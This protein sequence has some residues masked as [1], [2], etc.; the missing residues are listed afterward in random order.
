MSQD[1]RSEGNQPS[2]A[3]AISRVARHS[4]VARSRKLSRVQALAPWPSETHLTQTQRDAPQ[5]SRMRESRIGE[6]LDSER[7]EDLDDYQPQHEPELAT[8][9]MSKKSESEG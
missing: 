4:Q 5:G 1:P 7:D 8:T 2:S 9:R 6:V 3:R